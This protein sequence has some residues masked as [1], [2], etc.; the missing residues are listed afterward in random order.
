MKLT[1]R[2]KA[3][4]GIALVI[5]AIILGLSLSGWL[6][7]RREAKEKDNMYEAINSQVILGVNKYGQYYGERMAIMTDKVNEF[8]N[9]N[10][11][12]DK[13][14]LELQHT[15]KDLSKKLKGGDNVTVFS[16]T[17][18]IH[19]TTN[20]YYLANDSNGTRISKFND[21]WINYTITSKKDS[22]TLDL[23]L[24]DMYSIVFTYD[25]IALDSLK[26]KKKKFVPV[27]IV[28]S[29]SPYTKV[30]DVRTYAVT[31]SKPPR[32]GIGVQAGAGVT[33]NGQVFPGVYVGV[34]FQYT[35]FHFKRKR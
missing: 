21:A 3:I 13:L 33:Y 22:T 15:V 31:L 5:I 11:G 7:A 14:L 10:V 29:M 27:G 28:T 19:N 35:F 26:P 16:D 30:K 2:E 20:N 12:K 32:F 1:T 23:G 9:A 25:K 6:N 18:N 4:T 8:T 17:T 24:T 34:G